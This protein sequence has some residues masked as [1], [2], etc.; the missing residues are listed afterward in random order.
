VGSNDRGTTD[1]A[2]EGAEILLQAVVPP[3]SGD[4]A[5]ARSDPG[6]KRKTYSDKDTPILTVMEMG[7]RVSR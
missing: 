3:V 5:A 1:T 6:G 4:I 7:R 2:I